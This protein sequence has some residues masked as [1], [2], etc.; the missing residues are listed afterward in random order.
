MVGT[1]VREKPEKGQACQGCHQTPFLISPLKIV[2]TQL[3]RDGRCIQSWREGELSTPQHFI[4]VAQIAIAFTGLDG[5]QWRRHRRRGDAPCGSCRNSGGQ[6]AWPTSL[7]VPAVRFYSTLNR[8]EFASS[9]AG[10]MHLSGPNIGD[11]QTR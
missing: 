3:V 5:R 4:T 11:S 1:N 10:G 2:E 8:H 6:G 7:R 9:D